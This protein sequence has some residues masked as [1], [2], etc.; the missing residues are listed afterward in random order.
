MGYVAGKS[1]LD[2][3]ISYMAESPREELL[4]KD[5]SRKKNNAF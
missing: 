1:L 3:A 5:N 2:V 4:G